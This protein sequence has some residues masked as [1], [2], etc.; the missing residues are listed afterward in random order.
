VVVN[1]SVTIA[2]LIGRGSSNGILR[3]MLMGKLK[4]IISKGIFR[5]YVRASE[6][7][8]CGAE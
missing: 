8:R 5:E 2:R 1:T 7:A 3:L 6:V 4:I